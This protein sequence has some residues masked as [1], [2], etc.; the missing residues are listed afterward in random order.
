[1]MK[2]TDHHKAFFKNENV[3]VIYIFAY[4]LHDFAPILNLESEYIS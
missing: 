3:L 4:R 1:M 2:N